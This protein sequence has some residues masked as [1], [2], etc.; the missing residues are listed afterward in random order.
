MYVSC[1]D[2]FNLIVPFFFFYPRAPFSPSKR[3]RERGGGAGQRMFKNFF[4]KKREAKAI[5]KVHG[6]R[7]WERWVGV[8]LL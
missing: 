2:F 6:W 8:A 3:S 7:G 1:I 4:L 5:R